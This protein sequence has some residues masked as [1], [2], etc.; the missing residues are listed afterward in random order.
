ME[1][2]GGNFE[3]EAR[4]LL[5]RVGSADLEPEQAVVADDGRM[6]SATFALDADAVGLWDVVVANPEEEPI[7]AQGGFTLEEARKGELWVE[8]LGRTTLRS[9]WEQAITVVYGNK[10]NTDLEAPLLTFAVPEELM[11]IRRRP[12]LPPQGSTL[13]ILGVAGSWPVSR[14]R[15]GATNSVTFHVAT[16]L[17]AHG[18]FD[19]SLGAVESSGEPFNWSRLA[20]EFVP[21]GSTPDDWSRTVERARGK[22]G[23]SWDEV[24]AAVRGM[25]GQYDREADD[26]SDFDELL[27]YL[28]AVYGWDHAELKGGGAG[29][30]D[31]EVKIVPVAE[32]SRATHTFIITH[33]WGG[34]EEGDRFDQL[35]NEIKARFGDSANVYRID[36]TEGARTVLPWPAAGNIDRAGDLAAQQLRDL[37]IDPQ[38]VTLVGESF[39]NYVN[40]RIAEKLGEV[41][42]MLVFNPASELGGYPPP[43]F[44]KHS[45][46]VW[47]FETYSIADTN[48]DRAD[49]KLFL[50]TPEGCGIKCQH[51]YGIEWLIQRLKDDDTSW[52]L[53][54]KRLADL[55]DG[56]F[57][58]KARLDGSYLP[59]PFAYRF[60][61]LYESVVPDPTKLKSL[62]VVVVRAIDPEDKHGPAGVDPAGTPLAKLQRFVPEE[63]PL[64][65]RVEFW[66][67]EDATAKTQDVIVED[68]LDQGLEWESLELLE[69][70]FL[71]RRVVLGGGQYASVDVPEVAPL[72]ED[73]DGK[74]DVIDGVELKLLLSV[75]GS[76]DRSTGLVRWQFRSLHPRT[77]KALMDPLAGFLP[78][79]TPS[80]NEVGWVSFSV[81]PEPALPSGTEIRNLAYVKFDTDVYRPA[82]SCDPREEPPKPCPFLNTIDAGTP[83]S[84]VTAV[85]PLPGAEPGPA[86]L[87][88]WDGRDEAGGS[89]VR[90]FEV[91]V[92]DSGQSPSLWLPG[93][94]ERSGV[95]VGS[96]G[97]RYCFYSIAEDNVGHREGRPPAPDA[98]TP[99]VGFLRGDANGDGGINISDPIHVLSYLFLG[100]PVPGCPDAAD[101]DDSGDLNITDGIFSLSWLFL[102]GPAPPDPGPSMCGVDPTEDDL[103]ECTYQAADC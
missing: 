84:A 19:Y 15:P 23:E 38:K 24:L 76:F 72:D 66:N 13:R 70:G 26:L 82:P 32:S 75:E 99:P 53:F 100:G 95:F 41:D 44:R 16:S 77:R 102:G 63:R 28:I 57:D 80:G 81:L 11:Q 60:D 71:E 86:F 87:V 58:G 3:H 4:V 93:T 50:E 55:P 8:I 52:L 94:T 20:T 62:N 51:T 68:Q 85:T 88:E 64:V 34:T 101:G 45:N 43:D 98:C 78:P 46:Q 9:G 96:P 47:S 18:E 14:L 56:L 6:I 35:A 92:A 17:T 33:G 27:V 103:E 65:Y 21:A 69:F 49:H 40:Q 79:I 89:G 67:R 31:F 37:G 61:P 2:H 83:E 25:V 5:R 22:I 39:G 97:H 12:D 29:G 74:V 91:W 59:S 54:D 1:V 90:S 36:W 73:G 42:K 7:R 48:G 30:K 10:G